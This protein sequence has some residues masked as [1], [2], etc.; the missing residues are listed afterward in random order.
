MLTLHRWIVLGSL[1]LKLHRMPGRKIRPRYYHT[2]RGVLSWKIFRCFLGALHALPTRRKFCCW[3]VVLF[4]LR[5]WSLL[6]W[7]CEF[8]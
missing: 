3:G 4:F 7:G 6:A 1:R 5:K 2:L 8:L